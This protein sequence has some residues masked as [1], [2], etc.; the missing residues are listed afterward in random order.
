VIV[1]KYYRFAGHLLSFS[2]LALVKPSLI[3]FSAIPQVVNCY[4]KVLYRANMC[5]RVKIVLVVVAVLSAMVKVMVLTVPF[6]I[7]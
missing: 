2:F 6:L 7:S 1:D 4:G 5:T 3:N